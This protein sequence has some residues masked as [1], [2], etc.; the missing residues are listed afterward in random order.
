MKLSRRELLVAGGAVGGGLVLG[1]NLTAAEGPPAFP[2]RRAGA[3]QPNAFLQVTPDGRVVLQI[4]KTE[5]GQGILTGLTTIVAEELNM[6]PTLV[7]TEFA[8][9]HPDF[10]NPQFDLQITNASSSMITCYIPVREAAASVRMLLLQ[11]AA[12]AWNVAPQT[13]TLS[14]ARVLHAASG[15]E[16]GVDAFVQAASELPLPE[17]VQ[18]KPRSEFQYVGRFDRRLDSE[19]KVRGETRFGMDTEVPDA[20]TAVV[21]RCPH[22]GGCLDTFDATA[23]RSA[24]GVLAVFEIEAGIAVVAEHYWHAR[25][26]A[27]LLKVSWTPSDTTQRSSATIEAE[28]ARLLDAR[29]AEDGAFAGNNVI[30]AEYT[31]PFQAHACMEPM[32]ATVAIGES[33]A[34]VWVS[35]QAPGIMRSGVATAL[36]LPAERVRV[37]STFAGG[38]FGRRVYPNAVVEAALIAKEMGQ[39]VRVIW[40]R[41]DDIRHDKYRPAV[42]CRMSADVDGD[43]V[44]SWRFRICGPSLQVTL[45]KGIRDRLFPPA[46]PE[47]EF[48]NIVDQTEQGDTENI[49]GAYDS[50]YKLGDMDAGQIMWRPGIP[51]SFWRAVGHSHNGFFMEGFIDEM[52]V[53]AGVDV[54]EFRRRHLE[55]GSR[56]RAVLDRVVELSNWGNT[57]EG[58]YQGVAIDKI[59][60][61]VCGQVADV[62]VDGSEIRVQRVVCVVDPGMI[63]N[64]D[65]AT[66]QIESCIVWGLTQTLKSEITID[67]QRVVQ[68][69]FNDFPML[70]IDETPRMEV[71][72]IES[73]DAPVGVGECAVAPVAPAVANAVFQATGKRLRSLPLRL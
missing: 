49:E 13:L 59:K 18:L 58:V 1:F 39:P 7:E 48:N 44:K 11:A 25:R 6:S 43:A 42:K 50:P 71:H 24:P 64:P 34:D 32:N 73:G 52:A 16:S 46:L 57:P 30:S 47:S 45:I 69:N 67:D 33:S 3:W 8:G 27:D 72:F 56:Y 36:G 40:S 31:A 63:I 19:G 66:T 65:I 60:G 22:F 20:L 12:G 14:D 41:E 62:V 23:A 9:V 51:V 17:S 21:V 35:T 38:G 37:H 26:G 4:H 68:G 28:Q 54:I 5:M 61:A 2:N 29:E 10:L 70:R 53:H 55:P 15:R